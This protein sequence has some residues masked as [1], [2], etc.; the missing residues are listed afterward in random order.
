[1]LSQAGQTAWVLYH[2]IAFSGVGAL[3]SARVHH[4]PCTF[5]RQSNDGVV[6]DDRV[7]DDHHNAILDHEALIFSVALGHT[8]LVDDLNI[9]ADTRVLVDDALS[10]SAPWP[11]SATR[12]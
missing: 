11:A 4:S 9:R 2:S 1:M 10:H 12:P 5:L 3:S 8:L 6:L 7:L